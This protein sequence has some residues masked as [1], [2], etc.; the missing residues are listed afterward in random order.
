MGIFKSNSE[1]FYMSMSTNLGLIN[2]GQ[3]V[4]HWVDN[5]MTL[6]GESPVFAI[7][8]TMIDL[9]SVAKKLQGKDPSVVTNIIESFNGV[10]YNTEEA[11]NGQLFLKEEEFN[12]NVWWFTDG[13]IYDGG[14]FFYGDG[15]NTLALG[16]I[17]GK[18]KTDY[19]DEYEVYVNSTYEWK[20]STLNIGIWDYL[21]FC[22]KWYED[23]VE[24]EI[25]LQPPLAGENYKRILLHWGN[26][27]KNY[28][29]D[30]GLRVYYGD[31][32]PYDDPATP[33]AP[34]I[35]IP[36]DT[37]F[38]E[39]TN[40]SDFNVKY[41]TDYTKTR[42]KAKP[43]DFNSFGRLFQYRMRDYSFDLP[44][45][46]EQPAILDTQSWVSGGDMWFP[47]EDGDDQGGGGGSGSAGG[48][49]SGDI[50]FES[51]DIG[52]PDLPTLDIASSGLCGLYHVTPTQLKDFTNWLWSDNF[53][54]NILKNYSSPFEN[55]ISLGIVP[56]TQ[57]DQAIEKI[58]IGNAKSEVDGFKL[59]KSFYKIDCGTIEVPEIY[60]TY[61]D[62]EPYMKYWLYLP[63]IGIVDLPTDD[64]ARGG[65][66]NVTYHFDV[67]SGA[68]V[69]F[70][71]CTT[72][73]HTNVLHT[74]N[75]NILTTLP[76]SGANFM[77]MYQ[78]IAGAVVGVASGAASGG[79]GGA[80]VG[81]VKGIIDLMGAKPS[82]GRSGSISNVNGL[83]SEQKPYIIKAIPKIFES[84]LFKSQH[85]YIS[86][87]TVV[88]GAQS[89]FLSAQVSDT[90]L[91]SIPATREELNEIKAL[92]AEGIFI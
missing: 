5:G 59:N 88:I 53:F 17:Y 54:D 16:I 40:K 13:N 64:V 18:L 12:D 86:N 55:I 89:G 92:L 46:T 3:V 21:Y 27:A 43:T 57:F 58:G 19:Y 66:L 61:A 31:V 25:S 6:K 72:N 20:S 77:Q 74:Y 22:Q 51:D 49:N 24:N 90:Q 87:L 50:A 83:M 68:C 78:Q 4:L 38:E 35:Y 69:A 48:G 37:L 34:T 28:E 82:Y 10:A 65:S 85:G 7:T 41:M 8:P 71:V 44:N 9:R 33:A 60:S 73:G 15:V 52:V 81:A 42:K 45:F 79:A 32:V 39:V 76:I 56:F 11:L 70:V 84:S 30:Q 29:D 63:Y 75:G 91:S 36:N 80:A 1:G 47:S 26:Y 2:I 67:F 62:Y 23:L 14:F